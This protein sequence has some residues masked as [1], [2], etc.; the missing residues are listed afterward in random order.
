MQRRRQQMKSKY[1]EKMQDPALYQI[2]IDMLKQVPKA[3]TPSAKGK[4]IRE[5]FKLAKQALELFKE[6]D[7]DDYDLLFS[8]LFFQVIQS[9]SKVKEY[10]P[11]SQL[12]FTILFDI[13]EGAD[14][15]LSPIRVFFNG[16]YLK[17]KENQEE[18]ATRVLERGTCYWI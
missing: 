13:E 12:R 2:P 3:E 18:E 1:S 7:G 17:I 8:F 10:R 6:V 16:L 15:D 4:L 11:F 5:A 14:D 9:S